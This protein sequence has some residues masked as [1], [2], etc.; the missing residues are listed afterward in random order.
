[1]LYIRSPE[2]T[3]LLN[4]ILYSLT[5][6]SPFLPCPAPGNHHSSHDASAS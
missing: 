1:M 2:L 5:N 6:I 4:G 3:H